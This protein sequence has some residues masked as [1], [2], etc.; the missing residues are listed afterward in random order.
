MEGTDSVE[1]EPMSDCREAMVF[2]GFGRI[3][4]GIRGRPFVCLTK[5]SE[6]EGKRA[7]GDKKNATLAWAELH[8]RQRVT[9]RG[10]RAIVDVTAGK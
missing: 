5:E 8:V 2:G 3:V 10:M 7:G 9:H 6:R 1:C 4:V